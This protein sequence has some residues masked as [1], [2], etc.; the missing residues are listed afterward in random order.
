MR[1]FLTHQIPSS[2]K[3]CIPKE[4]I[5]K[6]VAIYTINREVVAA[7]GKAENSRIRSLTTSSFHAESYVHKWYVE[8]FRRKF[9]GEQ[10][11]L[12]LERK[13][14]LEQIPANFLM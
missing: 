9:Y 5:A 10:A 14:Q 3:I 6:D 8:E 13:R 1:V 7:V 4:A 2:D 12:F 11:E